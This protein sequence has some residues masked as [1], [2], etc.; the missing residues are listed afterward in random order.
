MS[1]FVFLL[2]IEYCVSEIKFCGVL[3]KEPFK[4]LPKLSEIHTTGPH[5]H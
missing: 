1:I 4:M 2:Y 5:T 3:I